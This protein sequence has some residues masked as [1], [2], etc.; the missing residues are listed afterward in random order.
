MNDPLDQ[1]AEGLYEKL[2]GR[3]VVIFGAGVVGEA[4]FHTCRE[5]GIEPACFCDNNSNKAGK[6]LCGIPILHTPEI[7]ARCARPVFLIAAADIQDVVE[8]LESMGMK[9]WFKASQLL[10]DFRVER[11]P[12]SVDP[13]FAEYVI[14][15][16][17]NCHQAFGSQDTLFLRSVDL[18][19]TEKCTLRCRDCSNLMQYYAT[20]RNF[21]AESVQASLE[22]L[23]GAIH[24]INE[25]RIIGGEPL[26][27]PLFTRVVRHA[28][29]LPQIRK[30]II[31][32]NGTICP[33]EAELAPLRSPKLLFL[34]THYERLSRKTQELFRRLNDL[35]IESVARDARGWTD[36]ALI[37]QHGRTVEENLGLFQLCCA[38]NLLTILDGVLYRCP[39]AANATNLQAIPAESS[40]VVRLMDEM[41]ERKDQDQVRRQ[42]LGLLSRKAP[43]AAC[44]YCLGRPY[45]A[46][47]IPPAVQTARPLPLP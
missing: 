38:K 2:G 33:P 7:V 47:E 36:C 11:Y 40:D 3:Q 5:V 35:G 6:T 46:P 15:T 25:V 4:L 32:T 18:V 16:C 30:V 21:S 19:I 22:V 9:E 1:A 43:L 45:G 20:P 28:L 39:F 24:S 34:I 13:E 29:D 44:D 12:L 41:G 14:S 31:Y 26:V 42:I 37:E 8:Q 17:V 10:K 27:S 23:C